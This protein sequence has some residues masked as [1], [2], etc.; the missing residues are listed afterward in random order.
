MKPVC[1]FLALLPILLVITSTTSPAQADLAI[2]SAQPLVRQ[3]EANW[4]TAQNN[5]SLNRELK[6]PMGNVSN[7][8]KELNLSPD[9]I[10]RLQKLRENAQNQTKQRRQTLQKSKQELAQLIQGSASSDQIR[11]K[12]QQVQS[13]QRE[14]A[15]ISFE[16]TLAIRDILTPEQ[17]VKL[18]EIIKQR[19][20]NRSKFK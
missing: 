12:R 8:A 14:V 9:Q 15:D 5:R 11:Q 4:K 10:Q 6:M 13:L 3:Q 18:Q 19:R 7:L 1:R 17:R 16:Q 2:N 20:Q